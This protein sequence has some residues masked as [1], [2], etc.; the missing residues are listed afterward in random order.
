MDVFLESIFSD[1]FSNKIPDLE[2]FLSSKK[3]ESPGWINIEEAHS[4]DHDVL[5]DEVEWDSFAFIF[6]VFG[7]LF[8][9]YSKGNLSF[10]R[11]VLWNVVKWEERSIFSEDNS[12][13]EVVPDLMHLNDLNVSIFDAYLI[14]LDN[15]SDIDSFFGCLVF[16]DNCK[17]II[18]PIPWNVSNLL[19]DLHR[20]D[21]QR[22]FLFY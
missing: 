5:L 18:V 3:Y 1:N 12:V 11:A 13:L 21:F 9:D 2:G 17:S 22:L 15:V 20:C 16:M 4:I 19:T 8:V 10:L 14:K 6:G 7:C